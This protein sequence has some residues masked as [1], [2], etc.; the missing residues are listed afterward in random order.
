[1][2]HQD[3][4]LEKLQ[5]AKIDASRLKEPETFLAED[6]HKQFRSV[7]CSLLWVCLTRADIAHQVVCL[8][9]EMVTPKVCHVITLNALLR[10]DNKSDT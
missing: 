8:Q 2:L 7:L 4:Y 10:R 5:P 1:M 9:S 6:E 3:Q